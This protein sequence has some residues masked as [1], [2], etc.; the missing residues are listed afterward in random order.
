MTLMRIDPS[1]K[2]AHPDEPWLWWG[3]WPQKRI[4][5]RHLVDVSLM[6]IMAIGWCGMAFVLWRFLVAGREGG[7]ARWFVYGFAAI[8]L[9]LV[10]GTVRT[11][12]HAARFGVSTLHLNEVPQ[13]LG[14]RFTARLE[15]SRVPA[16]PVTARLTCGQRLTRGGHEKVVW[17]ESREIPRAAMH[18]TS[19]GAMIPIEFVLPPDGLETANIGEAGEVL[20]TL[21][22]ILAGDAN[23]AL[24]GAR[25][26]I[27]IFGGRVE[28]V[29]DFEA[30]LARLPEDLRRKI[31]AD[32]GS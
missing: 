1:L 13:P 7:L 4:P 14:R 20:W 2:K 19:T 17:R 29:D 8:G 25:F 3:R 12:F 5:H 31:E 27:P 28:P 30:A 15:T 16:G 18:A 9:L 23:H 22:V 11:A 24:V 21:D 10:W 26:P 32:L 6:A